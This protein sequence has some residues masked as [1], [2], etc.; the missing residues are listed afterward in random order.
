MT[1]TTSSTDQTHF[2]EASILL[3][4]PVPIPERWQHDWFDTS[5]QHSLLYNDGTFY[6]VSYL[7][8]NPSPTLFC[9]QNDLPPKIIYARISLSKEFIAIQANF[10]T[11]VVCDISTRKRYLL[12]IRGT[13]DGASILPN[14]I[15][16][17]DHGGATQDLI[18]ITNKAI[19]FYK[20]SSKKLY[21]RLV[22]SIN[23]TAF[24]FWY[25]DEH[26]MI[27][28]SSFR[29]Q[30]TFLSRIQKQP[31]IK[32]NNTMK[33][34]LLMDGYFLKAEKANMPM[35]ELPPPDKMPRF[36][37]GPGV[38]NEGI[39]LVSS[40]GRLLA[41]VQY[42]Q[43]HEDL[44]T[45]YHVFKTGH[46]KIAT[47]SLG[48][49]MSMLK[50]STYDNLILCHD[51]FA[52]RTLVYDLLGPARE[53]ISLSATS[54]LDPIVMP[55]TVA[56][57]IYPI[58]DEVD[59]PGAPKRRRQ[60][61]PKETT[62]DDNSPSKSTSDGGVIPKI[63]VFKGLE[64]ITPMM[65]LPPKPRETLYGPQNPSE[66]RLSF[67]D[68]DPPQPDPTFYS[69]AQ[70]DIH[71]IEYAYHRVD[72]I[73][74]RLT[75]NL[76]VMTEQI[77]S[78]K[79][80]VMFLTRRGRCYQ[81]SR[82]V[83]EDTMPNKAVYG[84]NYE[85]QVAKQLLLSLCYNVLEK[86]SLDHYI[87]KTF[88]DTINESYVLEHLRLAGVINQ[89]HEV[90]LSHYDLDLSQ[91][92]LTRQ[93]YYRSMIQPL[94]ERFLTCAV[95]NNVVV[96]TPNKQ[97][98]AAANSRTSSPVPLARSMSVTTLAS[99]NSSSSSNLSRR[100]STMSATPSAQGGLF[101]RKRNA[102]ITTATA[103]SMS[104]LQTVSISISTFMDNSLFMDLDMLQVD[105]VL[106]VGFENP[107]KSRGQGDSTLHT[108]LPDIT[109]IGQKVK[110]WFLD[111][112][113]ST[114]RSRAASIAG[115]NT[116]ADNTM[117]IVSLKAL[118]SEYEELNMNRIDLNNSNQTN[119]NYPELTTRRD[120]RGDLIVTQTELLSYVWIPL[121]LSSKI[122]YT[123]CTDML[124]DYLTMLV[125]EGKI[126][127]NY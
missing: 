53:R 38:S 81:T 119:S 80:K 39:Y 49:I 48:G 63:K 106:D 27:M 103:L 77:S 69:T 76:E 127:Y 43:E 18:L 71:P 35:L 104:S 10:T 94:H 95:E 44:L 113:T 75:Y 111:F 6:T 62:H 90:N 60:F 46:E 7:E 82:Q 50:I 109:C 3:H 41:L 114:N 20:V 54:V 59:I 89:P 14:G 115:S 5:H 66:V 123:Y 21:C 1:S 9:C 98:V 67:M 83:Y 22:R 28:T 4:Q 107:H 26:R 122:D 92:F 16:W 78:F 101:V 42:T 125:D 121:M 31:Q 12:E 88:F 37:L 118:S 55:N 74:W 112:H 117:P 93:E 65:P 25:N 15:I 34:V 97:A 110:N 56:Y 99:T 84:V 17:S 13:N 19:E 11:I 40:Y 72:R 91:Y 96:T 100:G 126:C 124:T 24:D 85:S 47:L 8:D 79:E 36:E 51:L 64:F 102:N 23:H 70:F 73:M 108:Y 87:A 29:Q 120:E 61:L 68:L 30:N 105:D 57:S 32:S 58:F 33:E 52:K 2:H 116:A 45:V 86:K